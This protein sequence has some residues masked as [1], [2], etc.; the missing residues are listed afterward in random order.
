MVYPTAF[1]NS[2]VLHQ[3]TFQATGTVVA[4]GNVEVQDNVTLG[5][6]SSD[7]IIFNGTAASALNMGNNNISNVGNLTVNGN[8]TLGNLTVNGNTT[9]GNANTDTIGFFGK[10][11]IAQP[12]TSN[13]TGLSI[14]SVPGGGAVNIDTNDTFGGYTVGQVVAAL[15]NLGLLA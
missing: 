8:T 9:L 10:N 5:D 13:T 2:K 3:N 1:V 7:N 12:T 14:T 6:S 11:A 4:Q 15:K